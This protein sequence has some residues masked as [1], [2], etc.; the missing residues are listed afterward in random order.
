M[1]ASCY[2][3]SLS[4]HPRPPYGICWG[5]LIALRR[6]RYLRMATGRP[7]IS[8]QVLQCAQHGGQQGEPGS[9]L[10]PAYWPT[11]GL[12]GVARRKPNTDAREG[13]ETVLRLKVQG[14]ARNTFRCEESFAEV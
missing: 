12:E 7:E 10:G 9:P 3:L 14:R 1:A 4:V 2:L 6:Q 13:Q 8:H 5:A 11:P